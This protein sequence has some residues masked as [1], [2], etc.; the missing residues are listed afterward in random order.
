M[1]ALTIDAQT[2]SIKEVDIQMQA[3][4]VYTFF[5]SILIDEVSTLKD[6]IIYTDANALSEK[7]KAYFIGEQLLLGDAL[8]LARED[9]N[10]SDV[11]I[12]KE[13][14]SSLIKDDVNEF[15][16]KA[17]NLLAKTDI[18]LYRTFE[19]D[20]KGEA[21]SLNLEWT[22]YTFNIADDATKEYFLNELGKSVEVKESVEAFIVKISQLAVNS[23]G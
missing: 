12:K 9:F 22:L 6:H 5:S 13:E 2:N 7:K 18:N 20:K 15:Y 17:L 1:K 10:D 11:V 21:I 8:I 3:N 4:S 16:K 14:L 19:V 23:I